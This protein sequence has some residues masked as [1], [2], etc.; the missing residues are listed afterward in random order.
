VILATS[1]WTI[2]PVIVGALT[3][4]GGVVTWFVNS[5]RAERT[6]LQKLYADAY[7]A[8][9]SYQEYPYVISRRRAPTSNHPEIGGEERL[10]IS[11]GLHAVQEALNN[12]LAQI[13]TESAV[14]SAKYSHLV[15]KTREVAG[16]YMHEAWKADPLDNDPGM[17]MRFDY[18][19]LRDPQHEYLDALKTDMTFWR[20]A[21]P[22]L[23]KPK[24]ARTL[25]RGS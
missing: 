21:L 13:S 8:V 6:R 1:A 24:K 12:Y 22:R 5:V 18:S 23:R 7:S 9:I 25:R 15:Q 10:R 2:I 4:A 3:A 19:K 11:G 17:N 16:K 20:V 14:V